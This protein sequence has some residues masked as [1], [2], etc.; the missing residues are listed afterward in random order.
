MS[1]DRSETRRDV[2]RIAAG[3][4]AALAGVFQQYRSRLRRMVQLR[5][6]RRLQ[7][8]VDPSDVLQE[9]FLD[10]S[11]RAVEYAQRADMPFF[12]WLR[13]MTGQKLL[14]V[15]RR[16]LGTQSRDAGREISLCQSYPEVNSHL[17]ASQLLGHFTSASHA[18]MRAEQQVRLEEILNNMEPIDREILTLRHFEE[19]SNSEVAQVLEISKS[20]ASNRYIRALMRLKDHLSDQSGIF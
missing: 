20:A 10:I 2:E 6:D 13:M 5:L 14:E 11:R 17:L 16:H 7:G 3:D 15:H 12:L 19:L 9:A 4:Q 1:E 8:R 18:A